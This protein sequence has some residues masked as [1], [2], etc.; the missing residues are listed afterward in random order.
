MTIDISKYNTTD[1]NAT[2]SPEDNKLRLYADVRI[3]AE[4]WQTMKK[5][6]WKW[7]PRQELFFAFWSVSNEDFCLA[8]AG[9][10]LP[11]EMTMCERAE[12]KA[13]RLLI[14]A[15]KRATQCLGYQRAANDLKYRLDNNQP[16][17]LGHH[18]Q[19]KAERT[20][21]QIDTAIEKAKET[22]QAVGYWVWRAQGVVG[23]ANHKNSTRTI[24]NR[25]KTL[26]KDLRD[27]QK[28]INNASHTYDYGVKLQNNPDKA[29]RTKKLYALAIFFNTSYEY[30]RKIE[31]QE[32]DTDDALQAII[33]SAYRTI[34]SQNRARYIN[35]ILNR[36]GYEQGQLAFTERYIGELSPAIIQTFLRTHGADKPKAQKSDFGFIAESSIALPLHIGNGNQ[37]LELDDEAWRDLMEN[38]GYE[39]P[40]KKIQTPI[41]NFKANKPFTIAGI[42]NNPPELLEQ[43]EMSKE[44]FQAVHVDRR[45][46]RKSICN[47][48]RFKTVLIK[49]DG[50]RG[51]W[52]T[53]EKAVYIKDSKSHNT[54]ESMALP[55]L[56]AAS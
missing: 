27:A 24:F 51:Y 47:T 53:I 5:N 44:E 13:K 22:G 35:H 12:A 45:R 38:L 3:D 7:A 28:V 9:D 21:K 50:A 48:F 49:K 8:I 29:I 46:V 16:I 43:I 31:N 23:H 41:L 11:E 34:H 2:Y 55:L 36:L 1:F 26:L 33:E 6:G 18:S 39:V 15:E 56:E 17:L 32:I 19:R 4:D 52:D 54:P 14:L 37:T 25:I 30:R 40:A 20:S 42:Y 10:I